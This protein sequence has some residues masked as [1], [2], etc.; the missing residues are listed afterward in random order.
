[1]WLP[2]LLLKLQLL[3]LR[4]IVKK[5]LVSL[6]RSRDACEAELKIVS[7]VPGFERRVKYLKSRI[8]DLNYQIFPLVNK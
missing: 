8:E 3:L 1:M 4:L 6:L 2:L 5:R 7:D